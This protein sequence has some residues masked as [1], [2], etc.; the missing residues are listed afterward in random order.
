MV[1]M[2]L[3]QTGK[4]LVKLSVPWISRMLD[5][6]RIVVVDAQTFLI[7]GFSYDGSAP[8]AHFWTGKGSKPGPEGNKS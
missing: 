5:F 7:P 2:M 6:S 4:S 3:V 1:Y 8:D